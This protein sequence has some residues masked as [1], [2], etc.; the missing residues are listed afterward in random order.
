MTVLVI[1]KTLINPMKFWTK[2]VVI[3][4]NI[5]K[6]TWKKEKIVDAKELEKLIKEDEYID[7]ISNVKR[8]TPNS[9]YYPTL[10]RKDE[11]EQTEILLKH[12]HAIPT[13]ISF[14]KEIYMLSG[15]SQPQKWKWDVTKMKEST[16][17]FMIMSDYYER[18]EQFRT[19]FKGGWE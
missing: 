1:L 3:A 8:L 16:F 7:I 5:S 12:L 13:K 19:L 9:K 17:F 11:H 2:R 6:Y 18:Q 15:D 4:D 14:T 10:S